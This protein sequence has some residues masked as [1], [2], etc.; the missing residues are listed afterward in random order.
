MTFK[1]VTSFNEKIFKQNGFKLLESFKNNWHPD[2]EFHCYY[3]DMDIKNY[4]VPKAKNINYHKLEDIEEY[5]DFVKNNQIHN[6]TENGAVNYTE[7]LDGL[8]AAPKVFA[9]S[10]CAFENKDSWLMWLDPLSIVTK[11]IRVST[12]KNYIPSNMLDAD[13]LCMED[14]DYFAGFN[15]SKQTAVDL[16]GDLRGAYVSGEYIN[17]REWTFT[18]ILSRL[19]TIYNAHGLKLYSSDS[20][21][22]L[23]LNLNDRETLNIRDGSGNR[24]VALSETDTSPDILP[25]R[26]KQLADMV[27][28]YK[29]KTI[30]E[31]GTW[32]GGRALEMALACFENNDAMHYIGYDLFEDA[33][34]ATDKE[35]FNMK[36]HNT[37]AAVVSRFEEFKA[38]V[39]K[40]RNK[41]F[42][43]ELHKGNVRDTLKNTYVDEVDFALIGSGNSEETVRHEYDTLKNIPVVI[44]DHFYTTEKDDDNPDPDAV[45]IP[46]DK[47]Q[48]V[49]KV[50][51]SV[52]TKKV[53][54]EKTTDDGWTEFDE[55]TP[56]RKHVLPSSDRVVP[57]GHTHLAVFLHSADVENVPEDLKRV[58]IIV[59]PRDSVSK[60]YIA[61]NIKSNMK[62]IAED[63]W[64]K[65]HPPHRHVGIVVSAGPFIDYKKLKKFLKDNPGAKIVTVKHA[66]PGLMKNGIIPWGCILLDPRPIDKKSTHNI[67]RK[68]LF[69]NIDKKTNFFVASMT[70][71][72]VTTYL[73]K[74][75]V[76]LWG[77]H[78]FTDSLR[79]EDERGL[80]IK[81]QQVKLNEDLGI[82]QG[83]TLITG[84]TCAA[85]RAIGL[86]HT[87]GY[88]DLHLFGFDCCR[89]EPTKE[90]MTETTGDL[91]GGET[92]KPKYIKVN[93]KEASYWTTGELLAM[94]QDCEKVFSD[95]G[96]DGVLCFHGKDTMVADLWDIKVKQDTRTQF[97]GYYDG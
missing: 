21:K 12:L 6:G 24:V 3:Y 85:M 37:K 63:K 41:D 5:S 69:K 23:F 15:L 96:L 75:G 45:I 91:E 67:V 26:Y 72:S 19:L 55:E 60:E 81:N 62:V 71:P 65:K 48:G 7:S 44:M 56:T 10:E 20:F 59:H 84:G 14:A 70:D 92:P 25:N 34:P 87:M 17:Y 11:D 61:N 47:Y 39:K 29:P 53:N 57:A 30:L 2:F 16:L 40:E 89:E 46:D 22:D 58:P 73:K 35:E 4:T 50:F 38:H 97:K 31:T 80:Q 86:M 43:Y 1:I 76:R 13:F 82:P 93:V 9:I 52:P 33:T 77:W 83:A 28:F 90:E 66:L 74:Q 18:F 8:G 64:V 49:K 42:T 36:P 27:R 68:D 32:N 78:A 88:R 79:Q 94:A 95:P 54:S 51:D